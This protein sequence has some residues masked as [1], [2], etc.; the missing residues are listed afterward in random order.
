MRTR[1][2]ELDNPALEDLACDVFD[3]IDRREND[4]CESYSLSHDGHMT[5]T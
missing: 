1:L 2:S 5:V 3:E 4:A